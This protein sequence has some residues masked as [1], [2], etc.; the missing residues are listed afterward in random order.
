MSRKLTRGFVCLTLHTITVT[1]WGGG[2]VLVI[3]DDD[4]DPPGNGAAWCGLL[5]A[6][7]YTCDV[8]PATG[9]VGSL[10]GYTVLIDLSSTWTDPTGMLPAFLSPGKVVVTWYT[11]PYWLGIDSSQAVRDWIGANGT[12]FGADFL[13]TTATDPIL[14]ALP[15]GSEIT[16]CGDFPCSAL[17]SASGHAGAKVLARFE[18]GTST[19]GILR[20][21]W[22][23]GVAVYLTFY[24]R[25]GPGGV[26]HDNAIILGAVG[27]TPPP[28]PTVSDCGLI[29]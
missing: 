20:N 2:N 5:V 21:N 11:A 27:A 18:S 29:A 16:F 19:I 10:D 12:A 1:A 3:N 25:P 14:G 15:I 24:I 4:S 22:N 26:P 17:S 9:P 13:H 6:N 28:I 8:H 7:G 23:G